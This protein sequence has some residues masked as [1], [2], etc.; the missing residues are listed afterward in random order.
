ME[1]GLVRALHPRPSRGRVGPNS[2]HIDFTCVY[3]APL[4]IGFESQHFAWFTHYAGCTWV[5]NVF[6]GFHGKS[7]SKNCQTSE[8]SGAGWQPHDFHFFCTHLCLEAGPTKLSTTAK[9]RTILLRQPDEFHGKGLKV[10]HVKALK[11]LRLLQ[12][13]SSCTLLAMASNLIALASNPIAMAS[14]LKAFHLG[15]DKISPA[16]PHL[17]HRAGQ[18]LGPGS[19]FTPAAC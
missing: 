13:L 6:V 15:C 2:H 10:T 17:A 16:A 3:S 8:S 7:Q 5:H 19:T 11:P 4:Y 14:N 9:Q 18:T 12:N 1:E